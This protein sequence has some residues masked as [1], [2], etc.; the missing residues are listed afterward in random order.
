M[1]ITF[2][3]SFSE[4]KWW[5]T[6][7]RCTAW[8]W[9][10]Y[11]SCVGWDSGR[12]VWSWEAQHWNGGECV[13]WSYAKFLLCILGL[14]CCWEGLSLIFSTCS[15]SQ[16]C[17][18]GQNLWRKMRCFLIILWLPTQ[19]PPSI[20]WS[21][22]LM[23]SPHTRGGVVLL[24]QGKCIEPR[25]I[26]S[27]SCVIVQVR[28]VFRKTVVND[29]CFDYLSGS[30]LLSYKVKSLSDDAIYASGCGFDWFCS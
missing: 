29:W 18:R 20:P 8:I 19:T 14:R 6:R 26:S 21:S 22:S 16:C 24:V 2:C 25:S 9:S 11:E 28:V 1:K 12:S 27:L 4:I 15:V 30:H 5:K 3:V 10:L 13:V 17:N 23:N 7:D